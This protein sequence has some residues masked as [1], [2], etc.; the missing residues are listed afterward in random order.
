[1][2]NT[3]LIE[4]AFTRAAEAEL[5]GGNALRILCDAAENF[6]AWLEAIRNARHSILLECYI[7]S[8]DAVGHEFVQALADRARAGVQVRVL[9]DWLGSF[10]SHGM[11]TSLS[12]LGA[13]VRAFN[14]P[15]LDDPFGWIVR[16]HR[17]TLTVDGCVSFV[18]GLCISDR[19]NG[20]PERG[21]G[22][23]RDTGIEIRGPAVRALEEAFAQSWDAAGAP[24]ELPATVS[25]AAGDVNVRVVAGTPMGAGLFRLDHLIAATAEKRLWLTDAYFVGVTPYVRALCAA[26]RDGIDVRLLVP[27]ASDLPLVNRLSR[28]GYRPL[29]EAGVRVFEWNGSMLHAKTAV[30]DGHWARVGSTNLNIASWLANYEL[31][32]VIEDAAFA[33]R[34]EEMF[35]RDLGN[36]TEIVLG[37]RNRVMAAAPN[38]G[39]RAAV[40]SAGRAAAGALS[41]GSAFGAALTR[42]RVFEPTEAGTLAGIALAVLLLALIALQWPYAAAVPL[43]IFCAW[44]GLALSWRAFKLWRHKG[45][46]GA[47]AGPE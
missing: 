9:Y 8:D 34:M 23:W 44:A 35:E 38:P 15:R 32:V 40:G 26:A 16:D 6:P 29:L 46:E 13:Q 1:M 11:W 3:H 10:G 4:R 37:R 7:I 28:A 21:I 5:I 42:R 31:D 41:M 30:A 14:A 25:S 22:P 24:L 20:K 39:K 17:K 2:Q 47:R 45:R 33:A 36:A 18:S 12:G 43:F 19:W 27:G